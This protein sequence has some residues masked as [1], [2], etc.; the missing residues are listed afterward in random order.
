MMKTLQGDHQ[1][2]SSVLPL[3]PAPDYQGLLSYTGTPASI[4]CDPTRDSPRCCEGSICR[5][6]RLH[7]ERSEAS[8]KAPGESLFRHDVQTTSSAAP[9][10]ILRFAQDFLLAAEDA[11]QKRRK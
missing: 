8:A 6:F 5:C 3:G 1:T 7:A 10:L 11:V 9:W 4:R 2:A